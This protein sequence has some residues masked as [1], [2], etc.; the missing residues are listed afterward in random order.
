M[1]EAVIIQVRGTSGSGKTT[2]V[3][4]VMAELG[5]WEPGFV[6][7]RKRPLFYKR[8]RVA[9]LGHY[10][11]PCGGGDTIGSVPEI[12]A[13]IKKLPPYSVVL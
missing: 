6:E 8:E 5:E 9:V 13:A 3:R 12:F 1:E 10:E 7:G 11:V 2:A 4:K